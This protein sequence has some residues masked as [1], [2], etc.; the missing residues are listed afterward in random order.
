[1]PLRALVPVVGLLAL[2]VAVV[3]VGFAPGLMNADTLSQIG[4][5]DFG[6]FTNR[7]A[8]LLMALW[9]PLYELG[10]GPSAVLAAQVTAFV[11]AAFILLRTVFRPLPA[12]A[13]V[14]AISFWPPVFGMLGTLGR[15]TWFAVLLLLSFA[16]IVRATQSGWPARGR[17]LAAALVVL[18]PTLA[19]RQNAATAVVLA[20][21]LIAALALPHL[22]NRGGPWRALVRTPRRSI[23]AAIVA[24]AALT[25][26][27]L[28]TQ[29]AAAR[30]IGV[31]DVSPEQ[32]LFI[33]DI[34]ALSDREGENL[35]PPDVLP[36]QSMTVIDEH[37][38]VD[39]M[40]PF[41]LGPPPGPPL[42]TP[43]LPEDVDSLRDGWLDAVRDDPGGYLLAR[44]A[45]LG[46]QVSVT[47]PSRNVYYPG[48]DRG[49]LNPREYSIS[50]PDTYVVAADYL[51]LFSDQEQDGGALYTVWAYLLLA[52]AAALVLM[53]RG[54]PLALVAI[55]V[56]ALTAI[57]LQAGLFFGATGAGYRL[58]FPAVI[59]AMLA[60][61]VAL[62][63]ALDRR[64]GASN[65]R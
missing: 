2:P 23:L 36:D 30:A 8:P 62:R 34:A 57:T 47:G 4:E 27:L 16:F 48:I 19:A 33:Y 11:V 14:A 18:W 13:I 44:G 40:L 21:A 43:L 12:A 45:L 6:D 35:F 61:A 55:G 20:C 56:L 7:H 1:M 26:A 51:N 65:P 38:S 3:W 46:R 15:D 22:A 28:G 9:K 52:G 31:R 59:A 5:M 49:V 53:R 63:Y 32:Y 42:I 29:W 41:V 37:W 24:G 17:W 58:E 54:R 60:G 10:V 39:N 50:F 64:G 25:A